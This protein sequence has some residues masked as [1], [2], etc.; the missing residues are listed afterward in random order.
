MHQGVISSFYTSNITKIIQL[1]ASV[2]AGN[3]GGPLIDASTGAAFGVVTR[4]A[5]GLTRI[6]GELR[7]AIRKNVQLSLHA[8]DTISLGGFDPV[9]GFIAGQNQILATLDEIERQANVGIGY[10]VSSEHVLGDTA[11]PNH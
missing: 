4:R 11:L 6:F 1:D 8:Q 7:R 9:Q 2:N 5:T 10:A 3:S